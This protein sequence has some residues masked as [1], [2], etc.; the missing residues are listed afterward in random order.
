MTTATVAVTVAAAVVAGRIGTS[1]SLP[2]PALHAESAVSASE[3]REGGKE[4]KK[5][6]PPPPPLSS[7][8]RS[9]VK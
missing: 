8:L 7:P 4:L 3:R 9:E 2:C 1:A 5:K 6:G